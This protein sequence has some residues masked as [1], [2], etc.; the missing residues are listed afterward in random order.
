[1]DTIT[2]SLENCITSLSSKSKLPPNSF[3]EWKTN[4]ITQVKYKI[5]KLKTKKY[6]LSKKQSILDADDV[7]EELNN[8]QKKYV[9]VPIDK[10][11]N[12]F[13][14]ICKNFY[15]SRMLSEVGMIGE[16][17]ET[18]Q[19]TFICKTSIIDDNVKINKKY[20]L[21]TLENQKSLPIMYWTPK[22]HKSP[23]GARFII[24]SKKC[25]TKPLTEAVS[26]T[27]KMIFAH[28]NSFHKKSVFYSGFNRFWVVEN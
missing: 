18:Y 26:K 24:A 17:N 8:L 28:V 27:F 11:A 25:S 19:Q 7:K 20:G 23:V 5:S 15:I 12:N 10:A 4:I 16:P 21:D 9:I 2:T 22:M 6:I 13:A 3:D 14:F 1:M